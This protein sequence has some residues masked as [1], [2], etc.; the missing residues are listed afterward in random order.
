EALGHDKL[1]EIEIAVRPTHTAATLHRE[2]ALLLDCA[3]GDVI[4]LNLHGDQRSY[5]NVYRQS[6]LNNLSWLIEHFVSQ[7]N[8]LLADIDPCSPAELARAMDL[9]RG[10]SLSFTR[11][12]RLSDVLEARARET[13]DAVAVHAGKRRLSYRQLNAGAN[14]L[15]RRLRRHGIGREDRVA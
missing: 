1:F 14:R 11:D 3:V 12:R 4:M 7:A 5:P 13:P 2:G 9:G 8:C 15:A 10:P 6:I